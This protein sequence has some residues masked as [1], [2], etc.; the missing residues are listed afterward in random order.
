M[1]FHGKSFNSK[2][3]IFPFI[4]LKY[5]NKMLLLKYN[6]KDFNDET[7]IKFTIKAMKSSIFKRKVVTRQYKY[8]TTTHGKMCIKNYVE[9]LPL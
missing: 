3:T 1:S 8:I 9:T 5:K 7:E 6:K 4:L 2:L